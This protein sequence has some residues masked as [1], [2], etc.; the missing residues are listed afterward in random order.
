MRKLWLIRHGHPDFP[1]GAHMCLGRTDTPLGPLGR[2]Q[3]VLLGEAL[4]DQKPAVFA[5]PLT[6]CRETAAPLGGEAVLVPALAEQD[7]G[8]WDGLDFD[9][10]KARW[11]E[12]YARRSGE[13]LLVPP[14]AET[15][16]EVQARV[17][18]ALRECV[19]A[20]ECDLA[21]VAHAS[22]IQAI[23]AEVCSV[24]L[25]ESRPLRIPY[26]SYALLRCDDTITLEQGAA[27]PCPPLT[28]ALADKLLRAAAPGN[29]IEA[30]CQAVAA[31]ALRIAAA[32]PLA[33]DRELL[34]SAALLH[35]VARTEKD[36]ARLGAAWLRE[37]GYEKAAA[38]V[39]Q[40]HDWQGDTIDEAA[41]LFLADKC[42]K[43]D[44][45]VSIKERFAESEGRCTTPEA[46]AAHARRRD[47]ALRLKNEINE[48]CG[49]TVVE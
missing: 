1:L 39:E 6:R 37:L 13:P 21:V 41:V 29:R 34:A 42:V 11:P 48:I 3:A 45:R 43:E 24:P 33:L 19:S 20:C 31:E 35:D 2:M 5:S 12:L 27:R 15:L 25:T 26:A 18:P 17:T 7:M 44:R 46:R 9:T 10:I 4:R 30:H 38:L 32:L 8:P 40:H 28:Q 23:L 47:A 22:V 36:H 49:K 14:G 16:A